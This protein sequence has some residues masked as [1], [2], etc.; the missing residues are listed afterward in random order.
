MYVPN[1]G[2]PKYIRKIMED[3][4]KDIDSNTIIIGDFSIPLSKWIDLPN[5]ISTKIAQH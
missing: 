4:K 3:V 1:I 2:A 5:K